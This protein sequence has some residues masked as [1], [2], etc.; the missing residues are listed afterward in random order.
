MGPDTGQHAEAVPPCLP[1]SALREE[2]DEYLALAS[3]AVIEALAD[4]FTAWRRELGFEGE[5]AL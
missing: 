1:A 3:A 2:A 5:G 4:R